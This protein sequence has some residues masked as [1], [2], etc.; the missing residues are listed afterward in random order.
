MFRVEPTK[1]TGPCSQ[2]RGP[3]VYRDITIDGGPTVRLGI[4][5][6]C[7]RPMCQRCGKTIW[8]L[9]SNS[10]PDGHSLAVR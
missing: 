1:R 7:D 5:P 2:C 6:G 3:I 9:T 10:C 4:C 8:S